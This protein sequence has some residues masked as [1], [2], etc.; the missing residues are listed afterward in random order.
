MNNQL[1]KQMF[2]PGTKHKKFKIKIRKNLFAP[3]TIKLLQK[4]TQAM[5]NNLPEVESKSQKAKI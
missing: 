4:S 5:P 2:N 3:I 1:A